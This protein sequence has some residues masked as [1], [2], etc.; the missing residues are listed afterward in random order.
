MTC[1]KCHSNNVTA[2]VVTETELKNAHHGF[3]WWL[4][5]GWWWV[6]IKWI[7]LTLPALIFKIFSPK[8]QKLKQKQVSM[9]VC[10][11]CGHT[12]RA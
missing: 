8:R 4:L 10:H 11:N 2:Q 6:P 7:F 9:W 1:P 5:L 3:F 12:W